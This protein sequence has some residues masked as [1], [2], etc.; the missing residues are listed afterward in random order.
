MQYSAYAKKDTV[1]RET[2]KEI[3]FNHIV[4]IQAKEFR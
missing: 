2:N 1:V 3:N 4:Q